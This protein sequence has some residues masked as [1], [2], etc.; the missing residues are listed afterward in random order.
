MRNGIKALRRWVHIGAL[1]GA[2]ALLSA[3]ANGENL[4][5]L[6]PELGDFRLAHNIVLTENTVQ[7]PLS[8]E[9][10]LD[11]MREVVTAEIA[12]RFERYEGDRL[13]H[14]AVNIDAYVLAVPGVPL[15]ASPRSALIIGVFLWDDALGRPVNE[16]RRQ[17]TVLENLSGESIVGS[18]L[19]RS[20][21]EQ[22]QVLARNAALVI[23]NWMAENPDWFPAPVPDP[24]EDLEGTDNAEAEAAA[25]EVAAAAEPDD[26]DTESPD[27]D[28]ACEPGTEGCPET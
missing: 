26:A 22:L 2:A 4:G 13:Y 21:D 25:Q 7:G 1:I 16:E 15:V 24:A 27:A 28:A 5:D 14:L 6:R 8:R 20:A 12:R 9:A 23:E 3:C 17:F 19:T 11:E 10:D 18:G